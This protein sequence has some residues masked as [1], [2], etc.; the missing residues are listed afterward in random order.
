MSELVFGLDFGTTNSLAAL[1]VGDEV[2]ALTNEFDDKPH[3]SVVWYRGSDV[4]VGREARKHIESL[5]SGVAHGFVRSPKMTLRRDGLLHVEGRA[6]EPADIVANVL[7]HLRD[8]AAQRKDQSYDIS[9][10]VMTIPVDFAGPQRRVLRSAAR[11]AGIGVVQFVHEPAAALYAYIR[12]KQDFVR[13]LAQ[14][15]NRVVLVFDW[16]GGTLDLTVCR[17]LGGVVLQIANMGNNDIGG[18]RFDERLRIHIREKHA[19]RF[20]VSDIA[21]LEQPGAAASL[22]TQCEMA[23]IELSTQETFPV[24]AKDYLRGKGR[25]RNLDVELTRQDLESLSGDLVNRGLAEI[26]RLLED[27]RLDRSDIELCIATGGMVNMPAI[28]NGLVER[29]GARVPTLANRDRIIAEGA[30]WIAHDDLRLT[31]SKPIEVLTADGTG[32]GRHL[33]IVDAGLTLPIE[34]ET[35]AVDSRRFFSVDPRDGVAVFEFVKPRKV[36]LLQTT[37]ERSTLSSLNLLIDPE[38]RAFLER[39]ECSVQIDHDYIAHVSLRSLGRGDAVEA[40]FHELEFGLAL[41]SDPPS[42]SKPPAGAEAGRTGKTGRSKGKGK[43]PRAG[44]ATPPSGARLALRSNISEV[45]SNAQP[46]NLVPGDIVLRWQPNLLDTRNR[47]ASALQR[48]EANYY[49]PCSRCRRTLYQIRNDE[50]VEECQQYQCSQ[51]KT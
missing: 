49:I 16:G 2:Q 29:F 18:D 17:V 10:V 15:E 13:G 34:N 1:V 38:A 25:Q 23:K 11:K 27:A 30:A 37:D 22:L 35:I 42:R 40:E 39:M 31:L 21:A 4:I 28:W 9:R 19:A 48:D 5:E 46:W 43:R 41:P 36:G 44:K 45:R 14:L 12:A 8:A 20:G 7:K 26:D 51:A 3:P 50:P 47:E 32:R 24:I 33:S 6:L